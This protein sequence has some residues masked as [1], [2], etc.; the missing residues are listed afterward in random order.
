MCPGHLVWGV[1]MCAIEGGVWKKK[2]GGK[3]DSG[4]GAERERDTFSDSE[5]DRKN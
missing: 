2:Q 5:K 4:G 1:S 3:E